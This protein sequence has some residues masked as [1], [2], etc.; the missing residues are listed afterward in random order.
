MRSLNFVWQ[1]DEIAGMQNI[2]VKGA[3]II[4]QIQE[5]E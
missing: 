2:T 5:S 1:T 4:H 3:V